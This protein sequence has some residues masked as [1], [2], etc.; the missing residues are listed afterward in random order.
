VAALSPTLSLALGFSA[1]RP[2]LIAA[3]A[4]RAV[5]RVR[6]LG[7]ETAS[8]LLDVPA[9]VLD[10]ASVHAEAASVADALA[11]SRAGESLALRWSKLVSEARAEGL[12]DSEAQGF[13]RKELA[14]SVNLTA[15]TEALTALGDE[16]A[17]VSRQAHVAGLTVTMTW[18]AELDKRTCPKCDE[19]DGEE[20]TLPDEFNDLPPLHP[21]CLP[22][23]SL[24][25]AAGQITATTDRWFDGE[26]VVIRTSSGKNLS[27][28]PNH[29]IL[30]DRGYLP[31][32]LLNVGGYVVSEVSRD[33]VA[34]VVDLDHQYIPSSIK[35]VAKAFERSNGVTASTVPLSTEDFHGDG[36]HGEVTIVRSDRRLRSAR[37]VEF[38]EKGA[39]LDL[40]STDMRLVSLSGSRLQ[41]KRIEADSSSSRSVVG[42]SD[43]LLPP[44]IRHPGPLEPF[45]IRSGSEAS[46]EPQWLVDVIVDR[47]SGYATGSGEVPRRLTIKVSLD[48]IVDVQRRDFHGHVHNLETVDGFYVA[49]GIVTHN[50]RCHVLSEAY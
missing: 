3:I 22:P 31:A 7:R 46:H 24:I 32:H 11:A 13:A 35:N 37:D 18:S 12:A 43:L 29:P 10:V 16:V 45:G 27:C 2:T 15:T 14:S 33:R 9:S 4:T 23:D 25:T 5:F 50:C 21:R 44:V 19:L 34:G 47:G 8:E 6:K 36:S 30:T 40:V 42:G 49:D 17:R 1:A 39:E 26:L 28:T 20:R 41:D 38:G 48:D